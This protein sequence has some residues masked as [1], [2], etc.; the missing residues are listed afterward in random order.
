MFTV[1]F[2]P[3]IAFIFISIGLG[4]LVMLLHSCQVR[5]QRWT[6]SP[7]LCIVVIKDVDILCVTE[8][9]AISNGDRL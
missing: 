2:D 4:V 9:S 3:I 7:V 1:G 5:Q 6:R 8:T